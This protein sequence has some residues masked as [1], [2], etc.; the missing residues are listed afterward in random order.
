MVATRC[1]ARGDRHADRRLT[2]LLEGERE[3]VRQSVGDGLG[4]RHGGL[5]GVHR[6]DVLQRRELAIGFP[7]LERA[8]D[9]NSGIAGQRHGA[10]IGGD[11]D[12]FVGNIGRGICGDEDQLHILALLDVVGGLDRVQVD[13][14]QCDRAEQ[15]AHAVDRGFLGGGL[16][17]LAGAAGAQQEGRG[18]AARRESGDRPAVCTRAPFEGVHWGLLLGRRGDIRAGH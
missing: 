3:V 2:G 16:G 9:R 6:L 14:A 7:D 15:G 12:E 4:Q 18:H 8:A 10:D 5:G 1:L 11:R 17:D 13:V